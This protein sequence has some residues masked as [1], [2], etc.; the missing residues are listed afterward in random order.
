M[1]TLLPMILKVAHKPQE[2]GLT[3]SPHLKAKADNGCAKV[4]REA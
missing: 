3:S 2:L 4:R 1:A